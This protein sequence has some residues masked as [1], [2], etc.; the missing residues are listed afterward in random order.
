MES[1]QEIVKSRKVKYHQKEAKL[2]NENYD[3]IIK[4]TIKNRILKV[5]KSIPNPISSDEEMSQSVAGA[6]PQNND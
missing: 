3:N 5:E 6:I 1:L 4:N 2:Y